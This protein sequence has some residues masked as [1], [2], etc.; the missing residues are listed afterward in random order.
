[1][2][3][4]QDILARAMPQEPAEVRAIKRFIDERF[5]APSSIGVHGNAITITVASAAL[6]NTLRMHLPE[7]QAA[8][9]TTKRLV[10][11]IG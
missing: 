1:M 8:A 5:H 2:D 9:D 10:F 11:R 6:A 4:L 3:S 7:L